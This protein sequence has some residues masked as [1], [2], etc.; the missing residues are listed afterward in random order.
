MLLLCSA[1]AAVSPPADAARGT[2]IFGFLMEGCSGS[3]FVTHTTRALLDCHLPHTSTATFNG[4]LLKRE[5]A[6]WGSSYMEDAV[7]YETLITQESLAGVR[8]FIYDGGVQLSCAR[9]GLL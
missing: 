7:H 1:A 6:E 9:R 4:E 5:T 3:T 2:R 8:T